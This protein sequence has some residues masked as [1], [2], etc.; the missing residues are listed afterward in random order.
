M[1]QVLLLET[2][3]QFADA[4]DG[5]LVSEHIT[6]T[7]EKVQATDTFSAKRSAGSL[8]STVHATFVGEVMLVSRKL[9]TSGVLAIV[10]GSEAGT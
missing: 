8:Q 3:I 1:V 5:V 6:S 9:P 7:Y 2:F 10:E 4:F